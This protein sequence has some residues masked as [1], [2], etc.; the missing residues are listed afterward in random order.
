MKTIY[1]KLTTFLLIAL[2]SVH[3][4]AQ[5]AAP[6]CEVVEKAVTLEKGSIKYFKMGA[7]QPV[8]LLH[9]LFAQKEQWADFACELSDA[10]F[11]VYA[12]D[13]PGYGQSTGFAIE[14]YQ[15]TNEA[16]LLHLFVRKLGIPP[17]H[18]AG[19]SMGGA[20]AAIY[21]TQYPTEVLSL[22]FIGA[23]L[24]II[25]W[26]PQVR[27]AIVGGV[28]PFIP[29][30]NTQFDLEMSFLF[31]KPPI[32]PDGV[33]QQI[34]R[35]YTV[36]NLHYQKVWNIVNL[37]LNAL[38]AV[39]KFPKPAFIVW[40]VEDGI[41]NIA[42]RP[43]LDKKFQKPTSYSIAN[44]SH[45]IMLEKPVEMASL[46]RSFLESWQGPTLGK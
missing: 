22:G 11:M 16:D 20:I 39:N 5:N 37:D 6:S 17:L 38:E 43:L 46:Y 13:L 14:D 36:N 1:F 35:E 19:N 26:S 40:G 42:G 29:T 27:N 30:T 10:G 7:G 3:V 4:Y 23:P 8:L 12:P 34:L 45:L 25:G 24:G 32:I 21:S 18:I 44:A 15:L 31:A 9:G 28:N 2:C 41:F 33:K